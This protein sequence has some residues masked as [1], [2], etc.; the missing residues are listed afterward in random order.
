ML[1]PFNH[2]LILWRRHR[3]LTQEA[4][5]R[6]AGL[7]RPNL[8][9]IERGGRDGSLTTL[10]ALASALEI[11]PGWLVDGVV[12]GAAERAPRPL[13]RPRLE[14][15][16][17]AVVHDR[18]LQDDEERALATA[19]TQIVGPLL[20]ANRGRG[21]GSG[22]RPRAARLAWLWLHAAYPPDVIHSLIQRI[23]ERV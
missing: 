13:S 20:H 18:L 7:V 12:P 21:K 1:L 19:L 16:A 22:R 3:G 17:A 10:R 2:A 15:I 6:R 23:R 5:A 8:S 11:R 14:R 4:L 9:A